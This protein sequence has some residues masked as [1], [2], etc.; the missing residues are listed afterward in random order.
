MSI[1]GDEVG[2]S[3]DG[4]L[5]D[6]TLFNRALSAAEIRTLYYARK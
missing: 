2:A 3:C 4:L 1:A 6:D 5:A